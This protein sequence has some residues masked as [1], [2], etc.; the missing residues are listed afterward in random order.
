MNLTI[1]LR[2]NLF[3]EEQ[4]KLHGQGQ[5]DSE[6]YKILISSLLFL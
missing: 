2:L 5:E 4:K 6:A 3:L 1:E